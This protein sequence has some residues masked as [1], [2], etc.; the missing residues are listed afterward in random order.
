[1]SVLCVTG[2]NGSLGQA[3]LAAAK[4]RGIKTYAVKREEWTTALE[5]RPANAPRPEWLKDAMGVVHCGAMKH[6]RDSHERPFEMFEANC[7]HLFYL[8]RICAREKI[9]FVYAASDKSQ[10][11]TENLYSSSKLVAEHLTLNSGAGVVVRCANFIGSSGSLVDL[12]KTGKLTYVTDRNAERFGISLK[13]AANLYLD[14]VETAKPGQVILPKPELCK[15]F[16]VGQVLRVMKVPWDKP[17]TGLQKGEIRSHK[18]SAD[19]KEQQEF[20]K[21]TWTDE[22]LA[23]IIDGKL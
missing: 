9:L 2:A 23:L 17:E 6:V 14:A 22:E 13:A 20:D 5:H 3:V 21:L 16:T 4:E 1:M 8:L 15:K 19:D 10:T 11:A 7:V 18:M 12:I